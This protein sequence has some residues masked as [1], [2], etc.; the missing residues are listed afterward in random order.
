MKKVSALL[1]FGLLIASCAPTTPQARIEKDP[2]KFSGLSAK[3]QE[4]VKQGRISRGM[5][6]DAVSLAWGEPSTIFQGSREGQS[7]ERWDFTTSQPVYV[8]GLYGG[9][10]YGSAGYGLGGHLGYPVAGFGA[11]PDIAYV[12]QRVATVWFVNQRVDSWERAR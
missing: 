7:T 3:H 12:P 5:P 4:L 11:G 6:P 8:T 2:R 9:F 1:C 10:G